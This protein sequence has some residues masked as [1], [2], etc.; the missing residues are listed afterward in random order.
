VAAPA[1]VATANRVPSFWVNVLLIMDSL[2][3]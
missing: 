3:R 1:R 2:L